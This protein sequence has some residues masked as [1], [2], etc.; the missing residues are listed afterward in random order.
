MIAKFL[1][2]VDRQNIS[3]GEW[4]SSMIAVVFVR[5]MIEAF[6]NPSSSGIIASDAST[7]VHYWLFYTAV[8]FGISSI[9][10]LVAG[11]PLRVGKLLL[12]GLPLIW[13]GPLLDIII[14]GGSGYKILYLLAAPLHMG[15]YFFVYLL[16]HSIVTPGLRIELSLI[17][18]IACFYVWYV[19]RSSLAAF[20]AGFLVYSFIFVIFACPS[21]IYLLSHLDDM[22]NVVSSK[23]VVNYLYEALDTSIIGRN[24]LHATLLFSTPGRALEIEFNYLMSQIT[25]LLS[26][27]FLAF[28]LHKTSPQI[29]SA[30]I[31]N[32]RIERIG[33]YLIVIFLGIA[34]AVQRGLMT[35]FSWID[36]MGIVTLAIAWACSWMFAVHVND[37]ADIKIDM[38]SNANR[39]L[40]RGIVSVRDMQ[41]IGYLWLAA[42]LLGTW[43]VGYYPFYFNFP[44]VGYKPSPL[45]GISL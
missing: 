34:F 4:L 36:G 28:W 13:L 45:G 26:C 44:R 12:L 9:I 39:P 33:F 5:C 1:D 24:S 43:S 31:K 19:R 42:A 14:S 21:I 16:P 29:F 6:S 25:F 30:I 32:C 20:G 35:H 27:F 2:W 40:V 38:I 17:I 37:I 18:F 11:H 8:V 7:L 3:I 22:S 15:V 23:A 41:Q 10:S